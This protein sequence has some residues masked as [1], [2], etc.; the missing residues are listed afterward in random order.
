MANKHKVTCVRC[1]ALARKQQGPCLQDTIDGV[2]ICEVCLLEIAEEENY[3][4]TL[5]LLEEDNATGSEEFD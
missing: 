3:I 4:H 5:K 2:P 1:E